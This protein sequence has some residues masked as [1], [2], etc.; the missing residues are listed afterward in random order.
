[1]DER[2]RL[3]VL[4]LSYNQLQSGAFALILAEEGGPRRIPVVIGAPE[5]QSIAI[6]IE[7]VRPPRPIT[8]DLFVSF[9][10]AF[11]VRLREMYIYRFD[12]GIFYSELTFTDGERQVVLDARTSDAVA[13]VMRTGAPIYT[14]PEILEQTGFIIEEAEH[15]DIDDDSA[16]ADELPEGPRPENLAVEELQKMLDRAIEEENY[17]EA[18]RLNEIIK[19]KQK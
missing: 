18:A 16:P 14:T 6:R 17:E 10:Q 15:S 13:I 8:H 11:G 5:A 7:G 19:N 12:D 1:M 9:A 4:G 3:K 2:I